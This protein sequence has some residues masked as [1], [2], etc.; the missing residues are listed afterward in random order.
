MQHPTKDVTLTEL[1]INA[2]IG[3]CLIAVAIWARTKAIQQ[4][5][6]THVPTPRFF[7]KLSNQP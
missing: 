6:R 2:A 5:A 1:L 3:A 7:S 4:A